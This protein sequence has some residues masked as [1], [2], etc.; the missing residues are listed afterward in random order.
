MTG[1]LLASLL[2]TLGVD[3]LA[4]QGQLEAFVA[5]AQ[6]VDNMLSLINARTELIEKR[7][8]LLNVQMSARPAHFRPNGD[9]APKPPAIIEAIIDG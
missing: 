7:L 3:P 2:K 5:T 4:L 8:D 9:A 1:P 6:H